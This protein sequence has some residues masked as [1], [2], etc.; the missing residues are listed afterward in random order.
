[1]RLLVLFTLAFVKSVSASPSSFLGE[2]PFLLPLPAASDGGL[3]VLAEGNT[4]DGVESGYA[5]L[6]LP[7]PSASLTSDTAGAEA[8]GPKRDADKDAALAKSLLLIL[9]GNCSTLPI[10]RPG[11]YAYKVCIGQSVH[12]QAADGSDFLLGN[13]DG[14]SD[15]AGDASAAGFELNVQRYVNG[16][17]CPGTARSARVAFFCGDT[18][19]VLSAAE[20]QMCG[21]EVSIAHPLLCAA[22]RSVFPR[23]N[24][25]PPVAP[26]ALQRQ[27]GGGDGSQAA[28]LGGNGAVN[29]AAAALW[30]RLGAVARAFPRLRSVLT[31]RGLSGA[32]L[33]G[34][35][36]AASGAAAAGDGDGDVSA[37]DAA[38]AAAAGAMADVAGV[39]GASIGLDDRFRSSVHWTGM[40]SGSGSAGSGGSRAA[41]VSWAL[42]A[43]AFTATGDDEQHAGGA[44][45]GAALPDSSKGVA[46]QAGAAGKAGSGNARHDDHHHDVEGASCTAYLT[47]DL[48]RQG[49]RSGSGV[50]VGAAGI[51]ATQIVLVRVQRPAGTKEGVT[52]AAAAA[53]PPA[54]KAGAAARQ[55]S[56]ATA[57]VRGANRA[58]LASLA[59]DGRSSEPVVQASTASAA[60]ELAVWSPAAAP[61]AGTAAQCARGADELGLPA[62]SGSG[63]ADWCAAA[64]RLLCGGA[65][66]DVLPVAVARRAPAPAADTAANTAVTAATAAADVEEFVSL[67]AQF[68][69]SSAGSR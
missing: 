1:M 19:G 31:S 32:A 66:C 45:A 9:A 43:V 40:P 16:N 64:Q 54:V 17:P 59:S 2:A 58:L 30:S 55:L 42:Q 51:G 56:G 4:R 57:V 12:Q 35:G 7:A 60:W 33:R 10:D 41:P 52:A 34:G 6:L 21:Y 62:A 29:P 20:P 53:A 44:V 69:V 28:A 27:G 67:Q 14:G 25:A 26:P 22:P 49:E 47:D 36:G 18:F 15:A 3:A 23:A 11:G 61:A 68:V 48:R 13:Y 46:G 63:A 39:G 65:Q 5:C 50:A 8:R 37:A 38:A 24:A